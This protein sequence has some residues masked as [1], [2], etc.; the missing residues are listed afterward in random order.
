[1]LCIDFS[2]KNE[3]KEI[4]EYFERWIY[5]L[6]IISFT[7]RITRAITSKYEMVLIVNFDFPTK[8]TILLLF[9]VTTNLFSRIHFWW[10][11]R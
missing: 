6:F 4:I 11:F 9:T 2:D 8:Q 5:M 10:C 1:M 3:D 7:I